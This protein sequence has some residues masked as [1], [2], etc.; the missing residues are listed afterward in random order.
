MTIEKMLDRTLERQSEKSQNSEIGVLGERLFDIFYSLELL[1]KKLHV[2]PFVVLNNSIYYAVNRE[3]STVIQFAPS[4]NSL[5]DLKVIDTL[6]KLLYDANVTN[7]TLHN[8][9]M[10]FLSTQTL[11][12]DHTSA[13]L[14]PMNILSDNE[15]GKVGVLFV[16]TNE[17]SA[18]EL[19][20][21]FGANDFDLKLAG[22][23]TPTGLKIAVF[24][25]KLWQV[26]LYLHISKTVC[27]DLRKELVDGDTLIVTND[28]MKLFLK[29]NDAVVESKKE[30]ELEDDADSEIDPTSID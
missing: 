12:I 17:E 25:E 5:L 18:R 7:I 13:V 16:E 2:L 11:V 24:P 10:A 29:I 28:V 30:G 21:C 6:E 15:Y 20:D 22:T 26:E 19:F 14:I 4:L 23:F 9:I 1:T 8:A 3:D 27:F